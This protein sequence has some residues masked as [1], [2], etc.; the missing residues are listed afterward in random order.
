LVFDIVN[1]E[2]RRPVEKIPV[3]KVFREGTRLWALADHTV[4]LS[5]DG[6]QFDIE[7]GA[8][9]I[10]TETGESFWSGTVFR[11]YLPTKNPSIRKSSTKKN[12]MQ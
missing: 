2:T 8:A 4:L 9:P 1:A 5:K 6:R 3:K 10:I 11:G 12:L 7:D